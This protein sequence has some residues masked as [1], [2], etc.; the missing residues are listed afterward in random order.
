MTR[1]CVL[2]NLIVNGIEEC[3]LSDE[4]RQ[5]VRRQALE[6]LKDK[7]SLIP[8]HE[9]LEFIVEYGNYE[10]ADKPCECCGDWVETYELEL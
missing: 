2:N 4:S 9:L 6:L 8:T 5:I 7:E 10:S 3:N 1:G